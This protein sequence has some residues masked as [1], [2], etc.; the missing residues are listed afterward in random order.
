[1]QWQRPEHNWKRKRDNILDSS[2][3][4]GSQETIEIYLLILQIETQ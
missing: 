2:Q 4:V 1:M 3:G